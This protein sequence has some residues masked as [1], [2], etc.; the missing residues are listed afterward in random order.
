M[1]SVKDIDLYDLEDD[2]FDTILASDINF[3]GSLRFKKPFMIRGKVSGT[4]A[5]SG[6]FVIDTNASVDSE[7]D[8]E[9]ILIRGAVKGDIT[10]KQIIVITSTGSVLGDINTKQIVLEPGS[11]FNGRCTMK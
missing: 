8:C 6:D 9:R 2:D 5:A 1:F 11:I 3:K 7:I 4:I 10:C